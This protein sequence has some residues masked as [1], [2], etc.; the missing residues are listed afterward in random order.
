M[1]D[2]VQKVLLKKRKE[3]IIV[4]KKNGLKKIYNAS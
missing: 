4:F 3:L 2:V 1:N